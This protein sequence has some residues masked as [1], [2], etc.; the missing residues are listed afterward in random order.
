MGVTEVDGLLTGTIAV[1]PLFTHVELACSFRRCG[2]RHG[3]QSSTFRM[4]HRTLDRTCFNG[5]DLGHQSTTGF[6]NWHL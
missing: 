3:S 1:S 4:A 5:S 2:G 6:I